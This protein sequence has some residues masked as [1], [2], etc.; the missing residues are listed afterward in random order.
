M[1]QFNYLFSLFLL[2][3]V[4]GQV[5]VSRECASESWEECNTDSWNPCFRCVLTEYK[6]KGV[7]KPYNRYVTDIDCDSED[8]N[9]RNF[10]KMNFLK[11][12]QTFICEDG[13]CGKCFNECTLSCGVPPFQDSQVTHAHKAAEYVQKSVDFFDKVPGSTDYSYQINFESFGGYHSV[14]K[15][16]VKKNQIVARKREEFNNM[17]GQNAFPSDASMESWMEI[18]SDVNTHDSRNPG[19][20]APQRIMNCARALVS[21]GPKNTLLGGVNGNKMLSVGEYHSVHLATKDFGVHFMDQ[22]I[23]IVCYTV[24]LDCAD[25]CSASYSLSN[26]KFNDPYIEEIN[27]ASS[28]EECFGECLNDMECVDGWEKKILYDDKC[29]PEYHCVKIED[30]VEESVQKP[31]PIPAV[32][33]LKLSSPRFKRASLETKQEVVLVNEDNSVVS[34]DSTVSQPVIADENIV[35]VNLVSLD[36][37][38]SSPPQVD[39]QKDL[40]NPT[41]IEDQM[42]LPCPGDQKRTECGTACPKI[43]GEPEPFICTLQCLVGVCQCAYDEWFHEESGKCFKTEAECSTKNDAT[44]IVEISD[45]SVSDSMPGGTSKWKTFES[46]MDAKEVWKLTKEK[47]MNKN[48]NG[49]AISEFSNPVDFQSQVVAGVNYN[50][51]FTDGTVV[52]I[53]YQ[54]WTSTLEITF[55]NEAKAIVTE[56]APPTPAIVEQSDVSVVVNEP[57]LSKRKPGLQTDIKA[58]NSEKEIKPLSTL[59]LGKTQGRNRGEITVISCPQN[60]ELMT[61]GTL[62]PKIC[63][64]PEPQGCAKVCL[65]NVCQC[66]GHLWLDSSTGLCVERMDCPREPTLELCE[67]WK[68]LGRGAC[69]LIEDIGNDIESELLPPLDVEDNPRPIDIHNTPFPFRPRPRGRHRAMERPSHQRPEHILEVNEFDGVVE[70]EEPI[71]RDYPF[72]RFGEF[73]RRYLKEQYRPR[74][75]RA[76]RHH[77]SLPFSEEEEEEEPIIDDMRPTLLP[78]F[79]DQEGYEAPPRPEHGPFHPPMHPV[80]PEYPPLPRDEFGN[81][82][83]PVEPEPR[84][85]AERLL[86]FGETPNMYT[87]EIDPL[88]F[89]QESICVG[90]VGL[91]CEKVTVDEEPRMKLMSQWVKSSN[92]GKNTSSNVDNEKR[93]MDNIWFW[94]FLSSTIILMCGLGWSFCNNLS[95]IKS[96]QENNHPFIPKN[97]DVFLDENLR[98]TKI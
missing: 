61:C 29:C 73:N 58:E 3:L 98:P 22:C 15:M 75:H 17:Y 76:H 31:A 81:V 54:S 88:Y 93:L 62:C 41:N 47:Y 82:L 1:G 69:L 21:E 83:P 16:W 51:R 52:K 34:S 13:S 87:C 11:L 84:P 28:D 12:T 7:Q 37:N 4:Q 26:L 80:H 9:C 65:T 97:G 19:Q 66:P 72:D 24:A 91:F 8:F 50:F 6:N 10:G 60:Q 71:A 40:M 36:E 46:D 63:G 25:D 57:M 55:V 89:T 2:C 38:I 45:D 18:G 59:V 49:F 64:Q 53:F 94:C 5:E 27:V 35:N 77:D 68:C 74:R 48:I 44:P 23:P 20:T 33:E 90:D 39:S 92:Q 67:R 43:C 32:P 95:Q 30:K 42:K 78:D 85:S 70:S 56:I 96:N 79:Y 86:P 14:T